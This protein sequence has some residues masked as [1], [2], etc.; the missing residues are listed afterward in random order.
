[1]LS[2]EKTLIIEWTQL[3]EPLRSKMSDRES[4]RNDMAL[5]LYMEGFSSKELYLPD[6]ELIPIVSATWEVSEDE[7][8]KIGLT[9]CLNEDGWA[10][11]VREILK[12]NPEFREEF[13]TVYINIC[14]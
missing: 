2:T 12:L 13:D 11:D 6:D 3:P 9:K 4:F 8:R 1:M 5:P 14:W 10:G 7:I